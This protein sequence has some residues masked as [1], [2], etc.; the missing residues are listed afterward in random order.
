MKRMSESSQNTPVCLVYRKGKETDGE[1]GQSALNDVC[2]QLMY[3]LQVCTTPV[4]FVL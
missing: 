2:L 4:L 3:F 1:D